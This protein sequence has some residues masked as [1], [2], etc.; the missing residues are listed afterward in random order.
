MIYDKIEID[1]IEKVEDINFIGKTLANCK[2]VSLHKGIELKK[3][4]E[5]TRYDLS[6]V[7][8]EPDSVPIIDFVGLVNSRTEKV[9]DVKSEKYRE[10]EHNELFERLY[11]IFDKKNRDVEGV[12]WR[13]SYDD[14]VVL[15]LITD[16][17]FTVNNRS[18]SL[19]LEVR[20]SYNSEYSFAVELWLFV[21]E[22]FDKG[23]PVGRLFDKFKVLNKRHIGKNKLGDS[24]IIYEWI[25]ENLFDSIDDLE[26]LIRDRFEETIF[27]FSGLEDIEK[28]G[29]ILE[30]CEVDGDTVSILCRKMEGSYEK[31]KELSRLDLYLKTIREYFSRERGNLSLYSMLI[32][33]D[34][35][36]RLL[37]DDKETFY[38]GD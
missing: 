38:G 10:L 5:T 31:G 23:I 33:Y 6:D 21:D 15:R 24:Q 14:V 7:Q 26:Q 9:V 13:Y 35:A 1:E 11:K 28:I 36:G 25:E 19:G 12:L 27:E 30:R 16:R 18:Y 32:F 22:S 8:T 4:K 34:V 3:G 37:T 29:E 17:T 2:V 20:N